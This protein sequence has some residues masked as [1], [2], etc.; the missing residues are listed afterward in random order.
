MKNIYLGFTAKKMSPQW[1]FV[2]L[3]DAFFY[4]NT[5]PTGLAKC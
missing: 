3:Y 2:I 5:A 1:G 4:Q